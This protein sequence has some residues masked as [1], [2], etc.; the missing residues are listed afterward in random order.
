MVQNTQGFTLCYQY[1]APKELVDHDRTA[2][3]ERNISNPGLKAR[4]SGQQSDKSPGGAT[5]KSGRS[6]FVLFLSRCVHTVALRG[7]RTCLLLGRQ[8]EQGVD[9]VIESQLVILP[10]FNP[11]QKKDSH[12]KKDN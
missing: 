7:Q 4:E 5:Y 2:P 3:E 8:S 10:L 1:I 6:V 12:N 9:S 11:T